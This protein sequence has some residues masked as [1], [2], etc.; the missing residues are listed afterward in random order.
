ML[1]TNT[2]PK[3]QDHERQGETEALSQMRGVR[4]QVAIM[5]DPGLDPGTEK[6]HWQKD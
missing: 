6:I 2:H 4:S 1:L 5:W 3:C